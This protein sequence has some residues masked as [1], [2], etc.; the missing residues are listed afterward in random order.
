MEANWCFKTKAGFSSASQGQSRCCGSIAKR[1]PAKKSNNSWRK[2]IGWHMGNQSKLR[3][4]TRSV[5]RRF[6]RSFLIGS[7]LAGWIGLVACGVNTPPGANSRPPRVYVTNEASGD[8][9]VIDAGSDRVIATIPVGKRLRGIQVSP[10]GKTVYV[11]L[12]GSSL[13]G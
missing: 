13:A 6:A 3:I 2:E 8:V 10:N 12:S 7:Y 9:T 1:E 11:A 4:F 5:T